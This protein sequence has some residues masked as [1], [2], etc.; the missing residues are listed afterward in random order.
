[1]MISKHFFLPLFML[2]FWSTVLTAGPLNTSDHL[3]V[4]QFG[5][6][7]DAKKICVISDPQFGFNATQSFSPSGTYELRRWEDDA[8]VFSAAIV[9][10]NGGATHDQSG[11]RVWWFDFSSVTAAGDYYVYDPG[12]AVGSFQFSIS[13]GA[14]NEVLKAAVRTFYYQRC[15]LAKVAP[16]AETGWEDAASFMGTQQD[17]DCRAVGNPVASTSRDLTG[18]WY[19]AGDYNKYINFADGVVHDLLFAYEENPTIWGDDFNIPES[20]NGTPDI[21]DEIK[22]ELDWFLK[23]QLANGS[24]LH[25]ISVTDFGAASPPSADNGFRRYAPPTASATISACGAFAHA[26]VVFSQQSDPGMQ[27]YAVTL[28][29]AAL[30]AWNWLQNNPAWSDYD[31]AGFQNAAAEDY[32][33]GGTDWWYFQEANKICASAY[34]FAATGNNTYRNYFDNNYTQLHLS[35][36]GFIYPFEHE[37]QDA[38][39]YYTSLPN[40][41][42]AVSAN[43]LSVYEQ[44]I[45]VN[46]D[47]NFPSYQDDVDAYRAYLGSIDTGWGS[48]GIKCSKG[49]FYTNMNRYQMD[50]ENAEDYRDAAAGYI[51]YIHG[52]NPMNL[53]YLTNMNT[54]G[55][56]NSATTI[57]HAWFSDNSPQWDQVGVSTYGPPPGFVPGGANPSFQPD[58]SFTGV[59]SPPQN[60]PVLKSYLDWNTNWPQNSWEVTENGIYYQSSYVRLLSNFISSRPSLEATAFLEGPYDS[61]GNMSAGL[62]SIIPSDQPY[63]SAPYNYNGNESLNFIPADMVDWVLLEARSGTP[64]LSGN[65]GTTT[66]ERKAAILLRDGSIVDVNEQAVIFDNLTLGE[67]YYFCL[68]HRNHLD[69]LS[70]TAVSAQSSM[71]Y[72]F[73]SSANQAWGPEQLVVSND[74]RAMLYAGNFNQDT[75]IQTTDYDDWKAN[76][77]SVGTYSLTD[78]DLNGVVQTT[79]FDLWVINKA[80]IGSAEIQY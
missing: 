3:K 26:A 54:H 67:S 60:Q 32:F 51:H 45:T 75:A 33:F 62:Q 43:I 27:A 18:G 14:Y 41:S 31:N 13:N 49:Q 6:L 21:L 10:W 35:A 78:A 40:N 61:N 48:N 55:A 15:N 53:T 58:A 74:G 12:N 59:L 28:E 23:M 8:V 20:G 76:P 57:Y 50:A 65:R 66:V 63:D 22:Y 44:S 34:L 72:D 1:M 2:M 17:S 9:A 5:Y 52:I 68:R 25:K 24:V 29:N 47:D 69:V 80:K 73:S 19:D 77:A 16:Y 7:P 38:A 46:N 39:L 37:Y 42:N 71:T 30:A 4:D 11:D 36:W 70:S 64:N 56:E 79:D